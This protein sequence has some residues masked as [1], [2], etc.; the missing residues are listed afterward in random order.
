[1][2]PVNLLVTLDQVDAA[3]LVRKRS[4]TAAN[5]LNTSLVDEQYRWGGIEPWAAFRMPGSLRLIPATIS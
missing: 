3:N 4:F 2:P 1:V 5:D